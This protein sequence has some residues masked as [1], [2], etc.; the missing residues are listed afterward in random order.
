MHVAAYIVHFV[1]YYEGISISSPFYTQGWGVNVVHIN[2]NV[3]TSTNRL[4]ASVVTQNH[5]GTGHAT[6]C[7]R[8]QRFRAFPPTRMWSQ[9]SDEGPTTYVACTSTISK[10]KRRRR[11]NYK[12]CCSII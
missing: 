5:G 4:K 12:L 7:P 9:C 10:M 8:S 6:L 3:N 1:L 2:M 11:K